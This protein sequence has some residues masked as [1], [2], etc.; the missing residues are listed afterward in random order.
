MDIDHVSWGERLEQGL[1]CGA[2][3]CRRSGGD[4][5]GVAR[6]RSLLQVYGLA[7]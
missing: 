7:G 2:L 5:E 1:W 6:V 4:S 3:S